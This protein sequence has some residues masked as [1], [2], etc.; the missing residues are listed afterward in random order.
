MEQFIIEYPDA[1]PHELC[2]E[3]MQTPLPSSLIP[4]LN[5]ILRYY[6]EKYQSAI[7][8]PEYSN[9]YGQKFALF[10]RFIIDHDPLQVHTPE[11]EA[12]YQ[13]NMIVNATDKTN[14]LLNYLIYLNDCDSGGELDICNKIKIKPQMGKL[15]LFPSGWMY[16]FKQLAPINTTKYTLFGTMS[17]EFH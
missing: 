1:I 4:H 6:V 12:K 15:V 16:P 2:E 8:T 10:N 9:N 11:H 13:N 14:T 3:L 7:I 17:H 5:G